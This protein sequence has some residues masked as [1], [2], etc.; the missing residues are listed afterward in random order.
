MSDSR[1]RKPVVV[2]TEPLDERSLNW[3]AERAEVRRIENLHKLFSPYVRHP[4]LRPL[5]LRLCRLPANPL[6]D[7]VFLA[8]MGLQYRGATNRGLA[9]T[10]ALGLRNLRGYFG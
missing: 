10:A 5:I 6:F 9:E 2:V 1:V 3:L 8:S 4:R 7:A